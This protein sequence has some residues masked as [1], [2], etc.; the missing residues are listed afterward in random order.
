MLQRHQQVL[1][2]LIGLLYVYSI[3]PLLC[4]TFEQKFC[5]DVSQE[6]LSKNAGT[7]SICCQRTETDAAGETKTP[8]ETDKLCCSTNL[9][10][11]LPDDR[12]NTSEFRELIGQPLVS[13]LPVSAT[14][15][16]APRESFQILRVPLI[17][18]FFFHDSLSRRG[19][20]FHQS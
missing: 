2:L 11:V 13:I 19:P 9:E 6:V 3:C 15:P 5:H 4:A 18:T 7:R 17:P 20:P 1:I 12:H 16:V 8:S 14:S 10:L